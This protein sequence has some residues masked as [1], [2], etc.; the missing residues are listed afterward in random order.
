MPY[1]DTVARHVPAADTRNQDPQAALPAVSLRGPAQRWA[2]VRDLLNSD[3][4]AAEFVV[5]MANDGRAALRFGDGL[6]GRR[7]AGR[8]TATY[9]IGNG[10]AG[11]VGA[12]AI[13][14]IL[15]GPAG[16]QRVRNPLPATGGTAPETLE[17]VRLYAPQAFRSQERAVTAEDY[18]A[19]SGRHPDVQRAAAT[20]RWTGSWYTV[21]ISVD[22]RGG[23]PVDAA[24]Q[25]TLR[26]AMEPFRMAG[27]DLEIAGPRFVALDLALRVCVAAGH[28]RSAVAAALRTAFSASSGFFQPD[29]FTFGQAVYLSQ[30][31]TA[32]MQVPGVAWVEPV[33][34]DRWGQASSTA[35]ATGILPLD[36]LEIARLDNDP[37]AVE[38]GQLELLMEGGI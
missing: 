21:F 30:V 24:F 13:S 15:G 26:Q 9:R 32:A 18:A 28:F 8:L 17:Q 23:R 22:R 35:L 25:A 6:A 29:N 31:L 38:N 27:Y 12:E 14:G 36:R 19:L 5:E 11:N 20:V 10:R 33:R 16:I 1:S 2:A 34:F 3:R 37:S 4:F 7:P